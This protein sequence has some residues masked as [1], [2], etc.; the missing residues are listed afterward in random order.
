MLPLVAVYDYGM[1]LNYSLLFYEAQ[2]SGT[3]W[4]DNRISWRS[5]S[6]LDDSTPDGGNLTGGWYDAGGEI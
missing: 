4:P 1:A 5:A 3:D 6:A 2:R